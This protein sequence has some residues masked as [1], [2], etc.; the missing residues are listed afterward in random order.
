MLLHTQQ[1]LLKEGFHINYNPD[2]MTYQELS[3]TK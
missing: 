1:T 2:D 3:L